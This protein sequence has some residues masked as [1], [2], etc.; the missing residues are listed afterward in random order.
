MDQ[1]L[2]WES[3][4]VKSSVTFP[5]V[6]EKGKGDKKKN[7]LVRIVRTTDLRVKLNKYPLVMK[8]LKGSSRMPLLPESLK[9]YMPLN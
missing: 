8:Y 2:P 9:R 5:N 6:S 1:E 4:V 7:G 3:T